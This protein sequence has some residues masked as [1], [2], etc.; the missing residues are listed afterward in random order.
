MPRLA[1]AAI[2]ALIL[3][4]LPAVAHAGWKIDRATAIAQTVWHPAC[5][6][7]RLAYG[8][9]AAAGTQPEAGGWA[10]AGNCAIGVNAER[11]YSFEE[12]CSVVLHEAGH[13]AGAG[14]SHNPASVMYAEPLVIKT[15]A[16]IGQRTITRWTGVDRRCLD[17]GRPYLERHGL[18]QHADQASSETSE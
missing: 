2:A 18:L 14:H 16:R 13:V 8:D 11:H 6:Q 15:T 9:P 1:T 4:F 3:A 10:W 7:L 12:L 5:G 17:R